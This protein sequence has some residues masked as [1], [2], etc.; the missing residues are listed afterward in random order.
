MIANLPLLLLALGLLW[1]PRSWMRRG[2]ALWR[3][4][5]RSGGKPWTAPAQDGQSLAF[6]RELTNA[7]NYFD[8][9]RGFVGALALLGGL[10]VEPA[11]AAGVGA[12]HSVAMQVLELRVAVLFI[13]LLVQTVRYERS[14]FSL[15]APVFYVAGVT[16]I[17][18]GP[19]AGLSAFAIAWAVSG[20]VPNAQGFLSVQAFVLGLFGVWLNGIVIPTI[21]GVV[22][23]FT[24]VLLSMLLRRPLVVFSRRSA[25]SSRG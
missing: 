18:S 2:P 9:V 10:G 25:V 5:H 19:T 8:L 22:F 21:L 23:C 24:P 20:I 15:A 1:L 13:G 14:R 6:R 7:R 4:K 17:L 3:S 12:P 11:L 16:T